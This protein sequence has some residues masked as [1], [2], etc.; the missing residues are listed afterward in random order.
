[1]VPL[2]RY[3]SRTWYGG[4]YGTNN[5]NHYVLF[6]ASGM[7]FIAIHME[8][9]I[10]PPSRFSLG[11]K[12]AADALD[13]ARHRG[14]S[15]VSWLRRPSGVGRPRR[16]CLQCPEGPSQPDADALWARAGRK[17]QDGRVCGTVHTLLAN[18]QGRLNGGDGWLRILE[19]VP[20]D[21][22]INVK[23]YS[24]T[25]DRYETN[26]NSQFTL[27]HDMGGVRL[28]NSEWSPERPAALP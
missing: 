6:S 3:Q 28:P 8:Y 4:H 25:L 7:D 12:P 15:T 19:F 14:G 24:P 23:T 5:D 27:V 11:A 10:A 1:V 21:N 16:R 13:A 9:N 22:A 17:P 18:F 20:G 26:A 2:H